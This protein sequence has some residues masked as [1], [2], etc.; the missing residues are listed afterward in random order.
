MTRTQIVELPRSLSD[1]R[2]MPA[3]PQESDAV[4]CAEVYV[5]FTSFEETLAALRVARDLADSL[6]GSVRLVDFRVVPPGAPVEAPTGRSPIETD[7]FL[8]RVRAEGIDVRMNVYVCRD[9]R[10]TIPVV[11]K[12]H[13]LIVI[14]ARHHPWP[15]RAERWRRILERRGHFVLFVDAANGAGSGR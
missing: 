4:Q 2:E 15:T 13:S 5:L 10:G 12:D 11:F 3:R 6:D 9:A 7:A 8:D 1:T 14:G